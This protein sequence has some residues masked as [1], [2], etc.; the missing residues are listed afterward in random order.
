MMLEDTL[1]ID[2]KE[3]VIVSQEKFADN[4]LYIQEDVNDRVSY[5]AKI[6]SVSEDASKP[7]RTLSIMMIREQPQSSNGQIVVSIPNVRKQV[8]LFIL[9][10]ALG[11]VSDKEIMQY[12]VLDLNKYNHYLDSLRPS[13][14]D[15]G[16]IFT[17]QAAL[18]ILH[19]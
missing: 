14:H 13:V 8:P 7:V 18:N 12:C 9:M 2:G 19:L 16:L 15:A 11:V 1:L 6:R 17:Q 10:R 3:K 5:S 4:M